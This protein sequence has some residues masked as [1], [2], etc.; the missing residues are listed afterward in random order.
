MLGIVSER[1]PK[2][3]ALAMNLVGGA[4][5]ASIAIVLPIMGGKLDSLGP[6]AAL[7]SVSMLTIILIVV[8]IAMHIGFQKKGGYKAEEI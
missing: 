3:G 5:M 2:G 8:F 7:K 1:F 6:G 4:G